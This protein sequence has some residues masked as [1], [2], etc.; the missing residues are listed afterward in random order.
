MP[1]IEISGNSYNGRE[2]EYLNNTWREQ[3]TWLDIYRAM[4]TVGARDWWDIARGQRY[5]IYS[6][7]RGL[8]FL[9][10]FDRNTNW[11]I[12]S[13]YQHIED[14]ERA[15][16]TGLIGA[17]FAKLVAERILDVPWLIYI[18]RLDMLKGVLDTNPGTRSRPDFAGLDGQKRWHI[19]EAK[20]LY[21]HSATHLNRRLNDAKF[22]VN[23]IRNI[24]GEAPA[25]KT[26]IAT[27]LDLSPIKVN[28]QDPES[29]GNNDLE[30]DTSGY[31]ETYYGFLINFI[32]E[33]RY[34]RVS[35]R[36]LEY[37]ISYLDFA[38]SR[39]CIGLPEQIILHPISALEAPTDINRLLADNPEWSIGTDGVLVGN[40]CDIPE[41]L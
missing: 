37:L 9:H 21:D 38:S 31:I 17:T 41:R 8:S 26:A 16:G 4:I 10:Y 33:H 11:S 32:R 1:S 24:N 28:L 13:E 30:I 3:F 6:M 29:D 23:T 5:Y 35:V 39:I 14:T 36:N 25:C 27:Q 12:S 2:F 19:V 20:G 7:L 22:Q 40:S 18:S 15:Y 34:I